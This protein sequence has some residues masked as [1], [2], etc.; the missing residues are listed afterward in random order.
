VLAREG[1]EAHHPL[2]VVRE[3]LARLR[4]VLEGLEEVVA[5]ALGFR[6][7]LGLRDA[8]E[9]LHRALLF[10][11]RERVAHVAEL[12]VPAA[13]LLAFPAQ[14]A[15]RSPKAQ[16]A[17][18]DHQPRHVHAALH[19][20][21]K[22]A[23][24]ALRRLAIA[25]LDREHLLL[26][27]A[28]QADHHEHRGLVLFQ[29]R[30]HVDAVSPHVHDLVLDRALAPRVEFR[31]P[32]LR[33]PRDR[34]GRERRTVA[35]Q[36][37]QRAVEVPQRQPL[38]VQG[39]QQV[40]DLLALAL[41]ERQ[42]AARELLLELAQPRPLHLDGAGGQGELARTAHAVAVPGGLVA[43][44]LVA[45]ATEMLLDLGFEERLHLVLDLQP[46]VFLE[47]GPADRLGRRGRGQGGVGL[48]ICGL[49]R[50]VW[51]LGVGGTA[52][53]TLRRPTP[54]PHRSVLARDDGDGRRGARI[55]RRGDR[56]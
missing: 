55:R 27:R 45:P 7:R 54:F 13:L 40:P 9:L 42:H 48:A 4:V 24:P 20:A 56:L 39:R 5:K 46:D 31:L 1:V 51:H 6:A 35:E 32:L 2:P 50:V 34:R 10:A 52:L 11:Q 37:P 44:A 15:Q 47:G 23:L 41:E 8:A 22:Q 17:I 16:A 53:Q 28:R 26:A 14:L 36:R 19:Q 49:H 43:A 3:P 38:E 18:S 12:V 25:L 33:Q 29:A 21:P 30:L